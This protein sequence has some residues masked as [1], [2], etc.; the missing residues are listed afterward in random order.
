[1]GNSPG[2]PTNLGNEGITENPDQFWA[3]DRQNRS[4]GQLF[5]CDKFF[6]LTRNSTT[7]QPDLI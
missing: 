5:G 1:M 4:S 3:A 6:S 2:R 7:C